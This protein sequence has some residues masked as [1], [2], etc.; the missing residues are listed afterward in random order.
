[1]PF[2][3]DCAILRLMNPGVYRFL[4]G[5]AALGV[6]MMVFAIIRRHRRKARK[7]NFITPGDPVFDVLII[8]GTLML[9]VACATYWYVWKLETTEKEKAAELLARSAQLERRAVNLVRQAEEMFTVAVPGAT[10]SGTMSGTVRRLKRPFPDVDA[11]TVVLGRPDEVKNVLIPCRCVLL[12]WYRDPQSEPQER[13]FVL[14]ARFS[15]DAADS[16]LIRLTTNVRGAG[17]LQSELIGR[18]PSVWRISETH[19]IPH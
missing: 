2:S 3:P 18:D 15:N 17:W 1:M 13:E 16:G 12:I 10:V 11:V 9:S 5:V 8:G 14:E 4:F 19:Y 7:Q 6:F